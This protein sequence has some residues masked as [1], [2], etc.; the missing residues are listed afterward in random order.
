MIGRKYR[1]VSWVNHQLG[2]LSALRFCFPFQQEVDL[3]SCDGQRGGIQ[4]LP[5]FSCKATAHCFTLPF[6]KNGMFLPFFF[7][8][9]VLLQGSGLSPSLPFYPD[10]PPHCNQRILS[11]LCSAHFRKALCYLSPQSHAFAFSLFS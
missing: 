10:L 5:P 8:S 7:K 3:A 4:H 9:C 6:S 2:F 11:L 1:E